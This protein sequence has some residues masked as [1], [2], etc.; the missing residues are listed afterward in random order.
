MAASGGG[1]GERDVQRVA[2]VGAR[3]RKRA[4]ERTN[5]DVSR[6]ESEMH[7]RL[8]GV[9]QQQQRQQRQPWRRWRRREEWAL[10]RNRFA[11][12]AA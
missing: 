4:Y 9:Y 10:A 2:C 3:T 1:G 5:E 7:A 11:A 8:R 6:R 12:A